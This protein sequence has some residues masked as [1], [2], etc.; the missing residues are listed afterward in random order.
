MNIENQHTFK[1]I[2]STSDQKH[3][4]NDYKICKYYSV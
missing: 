2:I 1:P 3:I 4:G